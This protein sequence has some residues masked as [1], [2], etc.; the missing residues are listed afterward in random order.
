M[1][2]IYILIGMQ[3]IGGNLNNP[4]SRS[5]FDDFFQALLSAYQVMITENWNSIL[6]SVFA[7]SSMNKWVG[8]IYLMSWVILG[9][10]ILL[11]LFLAVLLDEFT[12]KETRIEQHEIE[13]QMYKEDHGIEEEGF[14]VADNSSASSEKSSSTPHKSGSTHSK[15]NAK[16]AQSNNKSS[17]MKNSVNDAKPAS[18][19]FLRYSIDLE[20]DLKPK[21]KQLFEGVDCED[22][23][24][25]FSKSSKIRIFCYRAVTHRYFQG[26]ILGV[27]FASSLA[28]AT[29]TYF[30]K[31]AVALNNLDY[32]FTAL[33][34]LEMALKIIAFGFVID[35]GSYLQHPWNQLDFVINVAAV[36]E[37]A[38]SSTNTSFIKVIYWLCAGDLTF[39][40]V[41]R[42]CGDSSTSEIYQLS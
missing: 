10:W 30:E 19:G 14:A 11:N 12:S 38:F 13:A 16:S 37:I 27:I 5:N 3:L 22:S 20:E 15:G 29:E 6:E 42:G 4:V 33:F 9:N 17:L 2:F 40:A 8:S 31:G 24:F 25:I 35:K 32:A 26:V 41:F 28:L 18:E 21:A 7:S 23:L 39:F 1:L 36:V 34:L